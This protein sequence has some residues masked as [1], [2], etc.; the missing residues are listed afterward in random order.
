[1]TAITW[2]IGKLIDFFHNWLMA[3]GVIQRW[4]QQFEFRLHITAIKHQTAVWNRQATIELI[5]YWMNNEFW[6][7][8]NWVFWHATCNEM[9]R[10]MW[11]SNACDL[12]IIQTRAIKVIPVHCNSFPVRCNSFSVGC[13]RF[14]QGCNTFRNYLKKKGLKISWENTLRGFISK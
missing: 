1:M 3:S 8:L 11:H 10:I 9:K 4:M 14:V 13:N 6:Q 7:R 12:C 2:R 5:V